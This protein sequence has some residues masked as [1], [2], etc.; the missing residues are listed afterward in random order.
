MLPFVSHFS[1]TAKMS[2]VLNVIFGLLSNKFRDHTAG[3]LKEGD[4]TN[5]K[6]RQYIVRELDDIKTKLD[7]LARK[8][9]LSSIR[10]LKEGVSQLNLFLDECNHNEAALAHDRT[11]DIDQV[12]ASTTTVLR[13]SERRVD[14]MF[15]QALAL[16][17]AIA[18]LNISIHHVIF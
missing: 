18:T 13:G 5:E 3:K 4:M 15:N 16:S 7:G 6:C 1:L 17:Q 14:R 10:F 9:L 12:E 11:T 8:D 2:S